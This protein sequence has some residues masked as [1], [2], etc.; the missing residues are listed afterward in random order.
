MAIVQIIVNVAIGIGTDHMVALRKLLVQVVV[1]TMLYLIVSFQLLYNRYDL[2]A[3]NPFPNDVKSLWNSYRCWTVSPCICI[4]LSTFS[5]TIIL[6][7]FMGVLF[8]THSLGSILKVLY[9][10]CHIGTNR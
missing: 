3:P 4:A 7:F 10:L 9:R 1:A 2:L 5:A 6:Y 8:N